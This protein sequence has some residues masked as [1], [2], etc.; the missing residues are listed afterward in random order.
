MT[1]PTLSERVLEAEHEPHVGRVVAQAGADAGRQRHGIVEFVQY[2]RFEDRRVLPFLALLLAK[3]V[4][5]EHGLLRQLAA[6]ADDADE[7]VLALVALGRRVV[8]QPTLKCRRSSEGPSVSDFVA[9]SRTSVSRPSPPT[10]VGSSS[11]PF[12]ATDGRYHSRPSSRK[13]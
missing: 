9:M 11:S 12:T 13:R 3:E 10:P 2:A 6:V 7:P 1:T 5:G 4:R 8:G